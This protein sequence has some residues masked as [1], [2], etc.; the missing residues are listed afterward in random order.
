MTKNDG[1]RPQIAN[2]PNNFAKAHAKGRPHKPSNLVPAEE[3]ER[4]GMGV[5][6]KE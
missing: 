1:V 3:F 6:A 5:A 4:K 2:G